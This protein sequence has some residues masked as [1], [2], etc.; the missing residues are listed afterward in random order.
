MQLLNYYF[1]KI[2]QKSR[3]SAKRQ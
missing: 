3:F 1:A 2:S